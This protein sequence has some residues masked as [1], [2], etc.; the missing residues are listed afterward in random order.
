MIHPTQ[1]QDMLQ[2]ALETGGDFAEVFVEDRTNG[3]LGMTGGVVDT[4]LSGRDFGIGIRIMKEHFSV[5]AYTSDMSQQS[6]IRLVPNR[7]PRPFAGV[8]RQVHNR[9]HSIPTRSLI[10]IRLLSFPTAHRNAPR[11]T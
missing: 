11:S 4:A 6:L 10:T 7:L 1:I 2:A 3:Q 5:Y 9:S 8:E